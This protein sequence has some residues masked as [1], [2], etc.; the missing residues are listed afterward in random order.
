M[1]GQ[2][3]L[4]ET[5]KEEKNYVSKVSISLI[6]ETLK[7]MVLSR[8]QFILQITNRERIG[9]RY[10]LNEILLESYLARKISK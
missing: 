9:M 7:K 8:T 6:R 5:P 4:E 2:M 10:F 3:K 1:K